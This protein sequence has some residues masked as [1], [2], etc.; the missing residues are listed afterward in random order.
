MKTLITCIG[1]SFLIGLSSQAQVTET[2]TG[3]ATGIT[4]DVFGLPIVLGDTGP[5]P[6]QGGSL[7][8]SLGDISIPF[9]NGGTLGID[10][11]DVSVVGQGTSTQSE[12]SVATVDFVFGPV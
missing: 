9:E 3:R 11:V 5:L 4:L 8:T 2:Y 1:F 7:S 12:A 10:L 6:S